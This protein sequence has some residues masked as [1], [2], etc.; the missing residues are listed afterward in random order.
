MVESFTKTGHVAPPVTAHDWTLLDML[1]IAESD[2]K[3]IS[4]MLAPSAG[5]APL[6]VYVT[7]HVMGDPGDMLVADGDAE[8]ARSAL[9]SIAVLTLLAFEVGSLSLT[10]DAGST[11]AFAVTLDG[12]AG[13]KL[14]VIVSVT[15][16][17]CGSTGTVP[18]IV[19]LLTFS[20][21][22]QE[23]PAVAAQVAATLAAPAGIPTDRVVPS[24][25]V[26]ELLPTVTV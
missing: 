25:A 7:V 12:D 5:A 21:A 15:R 24:A 10:P 9:V 11:R 8:T 14:P 19:A 17:R 23:A 20:G 3:N 18:V 16:P 6:F 13:E 22:G 4:L 26:S 2:Q 1:L